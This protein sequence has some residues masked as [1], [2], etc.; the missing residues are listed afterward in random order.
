MN[1]TLP[2]GSP[3]DIARVLDSFG[4]VPPILILLHIDPRWYAPNTLCAVILSCL[5]QEE[6]ARAQSYSPRRRVPFVLG[7][8]ALRQVLARLTLAPLDDVRIKVSSSGK[9][10]LS[11]PGS[12]WSFG[13]AHSGARIAIALSRDAEIGVDLERIDSDH[14]LVQRAGDGVVTRNERLFLKSVRPSIFSRAVL[15]I[16]TKKEAIFK[17]GALADAFVPRNI[18]TQIARLGSTCLDLLVDG[19][20][21]S[22]CG[23][24]EGHCPIIEYV[25]DPA[26]EFHPIKAP[27][28]TNVAAK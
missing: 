28:P 17:C 5:D 14:P 7:R 12:A 24:L 4:T 8:V 26:T 22:I 19:Y 11:S 9:P 16:W 15:H 2:R 1:S 10:Y 25:L 21:V 20:A 6:R 13:L 27:G 18:D 3:S 23:R